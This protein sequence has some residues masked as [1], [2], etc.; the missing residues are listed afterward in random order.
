[1]GDTL[2][3]AETQA[4]APRSDDQLRTSLDS[5]AA[6]ISPPP[7]DLQA[8]VREHV[9]MYH[10]LGDPLLHLRYPTSRQ[11]AVTS[12]ENLLK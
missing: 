9:L 1:L 8:E 3:L 5:L 2:E 10:L 11:A 4:L 12:G 7:V 6:G